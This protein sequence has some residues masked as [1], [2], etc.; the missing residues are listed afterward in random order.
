MR[1]V[2]LTPGSTTSPFGGGTAWST[3]NSGGGSDSNNC[4]SSGGGSPQST[5]DTARWF[6]FPTSLNGFGPNDIQKIQGQFTWSASG[7][8]NGSVDGDGSCS[9]NSNASGDIFGGVSGSIGFSLGAGISLTGPGPVS[10]N[11]SFNDGNT[12]TTTFTPNTFASITGA[13]C[14]AQTSTNAESGISGSTGSADASVAIS[15]DNPV[16]LVTLS[17]WRVITC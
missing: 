12:S 16:L 17:D 6:N 13:E 11:D 10:D 15:I 4:S 3:I 1:I 2:T 8:C 14:Q 9:S 7:D 5:F